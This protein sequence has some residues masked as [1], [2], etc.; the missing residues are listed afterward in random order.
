MFAERIA[1]A[2]AAVSEEGRSVPA[3]RNAS[4]R[5]FAGYSSRASKNQTGQ[6]KFVPIFIWG[7]ARMARKLFFGNKPE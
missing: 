6:E 7:A 3:P 2:M 5:R 1:S 4:I